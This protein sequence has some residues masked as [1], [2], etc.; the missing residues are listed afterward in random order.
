MNK[1]QVKGAAKKIGGKVQEQVGNLVG[2]KNQQMQGIKH[3]IEGQAE[4]TVGDLKKAV[5]DNKKVI[6]DNIKDK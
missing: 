6:K 4:E 3:Q 1:N 2:S 5:K